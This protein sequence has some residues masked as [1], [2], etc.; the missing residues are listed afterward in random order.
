MR[1]HPHPASEPATPAFSP[2]QGLARGCLHEL[3]ASGGD[4]AAS[5]FGALLA[6]GRMAA[7]ERALLVVRQSFLFREA[8]APY[9]PGLAEFGLDHRRLILVEAADTT[10]ALQAA[11]DGARCP[12]LGAVLADLY[13]D[14]R[15]LDLTASRR[16]ALAARESGVPVLMA[17]TGVSPM[18]SAA[19]TRWL[20]RSAP[21]RPMPASAP[22]PP[23]FS[24]TLLRR[25]GGFEHGEWHLEWNRDRGIFEEWEGNRRDGRGRGKPAPLSGAVVPLPLDRPHPAGAAAERAPPDRMI[26]RWC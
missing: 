16:L 24:L 25:R 6:F 10:A 15:A 4:Q 12:S 8:G 26:R 7:G 20:V 11:L 13:G 9:A 18:P 14:S 23:A 3:Y 17:R 21:S 19:E 22:G 5:A 2:A 1:I